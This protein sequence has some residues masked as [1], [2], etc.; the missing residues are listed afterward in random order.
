MEE[1]DN[2]AQIVRLAVKTNMMGESRKDKLARSNA[3]VGALQLDLE[4]VKKTCSEFVNDFMKKLNKM[5][6]DVACRRTC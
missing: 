3:I 6:E 4:S 2:S 5:V 1:I